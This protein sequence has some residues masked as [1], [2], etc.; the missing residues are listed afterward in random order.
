MHCRPYQAA[1][2]LLTALLAM[3]VS[4]APADPPG[5]RELPDTGY[6]QSATRK[7][8]VID[9]ILDRVGPGT[10]VRVIIGMAEG[11]APPGRLNAYQRDQQ[12]GRIKAAQQAVLAKLPRGKFV[13]KRR[14]ANLP[15]MAIEIDSS[16]LGQ[17]KSM[18]EVT[19]VEEDVLDR[20]ALASSN[21]VIG[22]P[23]AWSAGFDGSTRTVAV[24]DTGVDTAHPFFAAGSK[25]VAEACFSTNS[26]SQGGA[27]TCPGGVTR[28]TAAGSGG[29]CSTSDCNHGTHVAGIVAGNDFIG[30]E[31]GVARGADIIA[32]QVFTDFNNTQLCGTSN[33]C[34]LSYSSDQIAALDHVYSLRDTYAIAAVSMSL[35]DGGYTGY[36]DVTEVA[37]KAAI[38]NLRSVGIPTIISSGNNGYRDKMQSPACISSAISVAATTDSDTLASFSNVSTATSLLA[39]G[40]NITSSRPGGGKAT[41]SGTSMA[42][43]HVAGAWAILKQANPAAT[44][45]EILQDLYASGVVV[46]DDRGGAT[47]TGL[48]RVNLAAALNP[49]PPLSVTPV[50]G[51]Y[52]PLAGCRLVDTR[53]TGLAL[54]PLAATPFLAGKAGQNLNAQGGLSSGCGLPPGVSSIHVNLTV[55]SEGSS[56]YLRAWPF[57]QPEPNA[58]VFAWNGGNATNALSLAICTGTGCSSDFVVKLYEDTSGVELVIDLLGYTIE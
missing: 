52:V 8:A 50:S 4:G 7:S 5:L 21:G 25:I 30:P 35:G 2:L 9:R 13:E 33:P 45:D 57:G 26:S 43:P 38:D 17:L 19:S 12:R 36:C 54:T 40:V 47:I 51:S 48:R 31:F 53:Q 39:P 42:A 22:S 18:A 56:G 44:F 32:M 27:S 49:D 29:I 24:L 1:I 34:S 16:Q 55:V 15:F 41:L 37:R 3:T 28:S 58:T 6:A 14:F 10:S 46:D 20:P 11:F 23:D